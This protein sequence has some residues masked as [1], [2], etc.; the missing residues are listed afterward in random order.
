MPRRLR[1]LANKCICNKHILVGTKIGAGGFGSVYNVVGHTKYVV[2]IQKNDAYAKAEIDAYMRLAS[3]KV[4]PKMY[5]AWTC[6]G[7]AYIL[8]EKMYGCKR[9]PLPRVRLLLAEMLKQGWIHA[10]VHYGNI[11]CTKKGRVVLI[12]FGYA[13]RKGEYPYENRPRLTFGYL[14]AKQASQLRDM[15]T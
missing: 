5:A 14:K 4:T 6:R 15:V 12:D 3:L 11:M 13:V 1:E 9:D 8:L 2:K 10:D 7:K